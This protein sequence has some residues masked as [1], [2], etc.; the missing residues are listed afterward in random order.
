MS[1]INRSGP[2][3][4]SAHSAAVPRLYAGIFAVTGW[5]LYLALDILMSL[6]MNLSDR[7]TF[8]RS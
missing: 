3:E 2:F 4:P 8:V 5:R 6:I 7:K 1:S